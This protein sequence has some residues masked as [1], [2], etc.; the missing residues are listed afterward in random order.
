MCLHVRKL[1]MLMLVHCSCNVPHALAQGQQM[2]DGVRLFPGS[3]HKDLNFYPDTCM[4]PV[5]DRMLSR[6]SACLQWLQL[7]VCTPAECEPASMRFC[8]TTCVT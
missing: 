4:P 8:I 6:T 2:S 1:V 7:E 5:W 3:D